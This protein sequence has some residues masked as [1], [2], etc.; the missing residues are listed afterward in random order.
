MNGWN[1]GPN[2]ISNIVEPRKT[3]LMIEED[4]YRGYNVNSWIISPPNTWTD[5][6]AGSHDGGDNLTFADGHMEYWKWID[7]DTLTLTPNMHGD[8]DPGSLDLARLAEVYKDP[9]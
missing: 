9:R 1:G 8:S 7:P 5:Y 4:D 2:K 6:V 3:L